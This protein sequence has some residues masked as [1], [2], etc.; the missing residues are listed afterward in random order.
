M[1]GRQNGPRRRTPSQGARRAGGSTRSVNLWPRR[2]ITGTGLLVVAALLVWSAVSVVKALLAG[3]PPD[4][5]PQ[6]ASQSGADASGYPLGADQR[7]TADGIVTGNATVDV[8]V[9]LEA[10][11]EVRATASDATSGQA[12]PIGVSL[13]NRGGVACRVGLSSLAVRIT[14]G[15][16]TVYDS[17]ACEQGAESEQVLL[18]SP[19]RTWSGTLG[20]DGLV[21]VNGCA[22]P[23]GGERAA[24]PGTYQLRVFLD[25]KDTGNHVVFDVGAALP[26]K[27][28]PAPQ[29]QSGVQSG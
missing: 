21:H 5:Q 18:L 10:N 26:P 17:A 1:P 29:S 15:D 2:I 13:R 8:P 7:A 4:P 11:L 3:S 22:A 27:P 9:C 25:G 20:W 6:S 23:P 16:L 19:D 12:V 28:S 24:D 14:T